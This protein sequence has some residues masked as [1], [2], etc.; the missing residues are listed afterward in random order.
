MKFFAINGS[1]RRNCNT[2]QLLDKSL[3]GVKSV[4]PEATAERIDLYAFP[5]MG[6][7]AVL[8]VKG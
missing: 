6:V 4:F 7:E 5:F 3:E 2:S 8:H 1:P